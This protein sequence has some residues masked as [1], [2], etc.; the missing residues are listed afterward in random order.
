MLRTKTDYPGFYGILFEKAV[1][2]WWCGLAQ[3]SK[4]TFFDL[5]NN[6]PLEPLYKDACLSNMKKLNWI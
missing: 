2:G 1:S 4:D 3:E 5:Y 6:Y